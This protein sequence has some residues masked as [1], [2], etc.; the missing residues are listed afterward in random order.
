MKTMINIKA[1]RAVKEEAQKLA[2]ELGLSLSAVVSASLKQFV[3]NREI[4]LSAG[5]EP[6][7]Y[8]KKVLRNA[9]KDIRSGKNFS[10]PF[11]TP[12][13]IRRYLDRL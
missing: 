1:D 8:L 9:E 12:E 10:G 13:E 5:L 6:S 4:H 3:R 7:P 11:H 2:K